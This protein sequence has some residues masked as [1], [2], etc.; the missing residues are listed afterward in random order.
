MWPRLYIVTFQGFQIF[1]CEFGERFVFLPQE[2]VTC[3]AKLYYYWEGMFKV[4]SFVLC[5][6][7]KNNVI[8]FCKTFLGKMGKN[9]KNLVKL[10][11]NCT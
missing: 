8:C 4:Q 7:V 5:Q 2:K 10:R 6:Y 11:N 3:N 1:V 9:I